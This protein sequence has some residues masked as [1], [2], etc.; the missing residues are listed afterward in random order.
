[1]KLIKLLPA[2]LLF[3]GVTFAQEWVDLKHNPN[4]NF[5]TIQAKFNEY[6]KDKDETE[7]GKG[8]KQFK[9]WENYAEPRVYPH[10]DLNVLNQIPKNY[11]DWLENYNATHNQN[12]ANA[13]FESNNMIASTTWTAI[14]PMG[15]ISGNAGGQLLK[16]GR[17]NFVTIDPTNINN[18]WVGAPC[19][20][21]WKSTNGGT[22]WTTNTDNLV[23]PGCSDLAIDPT[24]TSIM[25]L[26]T[27]D[28]DAGDYNSVGVLKSTNGGNTWAT[29][30]LTFNLNSGYLIRKLAINPSNTQIIMAATNA[31][32]YRSTN[33]GA[34][35]SVVSTYST[36]CHDI[37]FQ[38][39]N[40][41]IVYVAGPTFKKSTDGGV[42][43]TTISS[44]IPTTGINRMAIAVTP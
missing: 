6:W 24:N 30:G 10:G 2:C 15:A 19:G 41:N 40:P 25:Y 28:G 12:S 14:G 13:K 43:F 1:M 9:R 27:G 32:V 42:T 22:S 31:G 20:G 11:Q 34:N 7:K 5:Y 16:S 35:W 17:L 8:Y 38:P 36:T 33:G 29:T 21:L 39:G 18:L 3:T 44:G 4:A 37:E 26:A 23:I